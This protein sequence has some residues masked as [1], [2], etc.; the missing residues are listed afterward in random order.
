MYREGDTWFRDMKP[1][2]IDNAVQ[3][4]DRV[5]DSLSWLA[6]QMVND[7]RFAIAAVKFWW[8][9]LM[10]AK[11][12]VPP[13]V[14]TDA[15]YQA[16][17]NAYRAQELQISTLASRFRSNNLNARELLTDMI[18]SPWFRAKAATPEASDRSVELA[19]LG[20]DRLLTPEELDAKN[21]AILG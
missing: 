7:S 11:A 4:S 8:P 18:L 3:P 10:G 12:L 19:D 17:R 14:E 5:D 1:P 15:D 20:V 6:E 21:E 2:G 9:A 16:R 13:E